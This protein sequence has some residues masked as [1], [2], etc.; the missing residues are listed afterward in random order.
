[1]AVIANQTRL[2][3]AERPALRDHLHGAWWPR[4]GDIAKELAPLLRAVTSRARVVGVAL[5]RDEWPDAPLAL[6]QTITGR[7]KISWYGLPEPHLMV[8]RLDEGGK[9]SDTK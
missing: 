2:L 8:L 3:L 6:D 1:M 5:N 7:V 4:S 9:E